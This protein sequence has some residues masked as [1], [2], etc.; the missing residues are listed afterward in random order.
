MECKFHSS[1]PGQA[2]KH[3]VRTGCAGAQCPQVTQGQFQETLE[4][5]FAGCWRKSAPG[6][7]AEAIPGKTAAPTEAL[8][9][10]PARLSESSS[11]RAPGWDVLHTH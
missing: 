2:H 5:L 3:L 10:S 9:L 1:S 8:S 7:Q 11:S 6:L 4:E